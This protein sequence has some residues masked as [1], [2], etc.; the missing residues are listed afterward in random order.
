MRLFHAS[1]TIIEKPDTLHSR[2]NLDFGRG[3][4]LTSI[5]EQAIHYAQ[6]FIRRKMEAYINEYELDEEIPDFTTKAFLN[7]D[8]KWLDYVALCRKELF[9]LNL[10][11]PFQVELP[12]IRFS[13]QSICILQGSSQRKRHLDGSNTKSLTTKY[14]S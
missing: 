14:A 4:Y 9:P 12:T 1:Y 8:E 7:Y 2:C 3:F 10:L 6:R 13:T 5:R 11:M